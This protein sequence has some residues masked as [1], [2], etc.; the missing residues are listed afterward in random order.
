MP[1]YILFNEN[2]SSLRKG[3]KLSTPQIYEVSVLFPGSIS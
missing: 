2:V 3:G 1:T